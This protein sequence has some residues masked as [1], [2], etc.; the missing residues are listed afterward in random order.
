MKIYVASSWRNP[1]QPAVVERLRA[2]GH[3]VYDFRH[4]AEGDNGFHWSEIDEGWQQWT[5]ERYVAALEHPIAE[6]GF[7]KDKA[8]LDW[9][10]ACVLVLPC[11]RS[12]HLELGYAIGKGKRTAIVIAPVAGHS[13]RSDAPCSSCGDL[14]GCWVPANVMKVEP[15][16]M[17]KLADRICLS[18]DA[19][20][21][22][23]K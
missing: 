15:E 9:C 23:L 5:P 16:L 1:F 11:G 19:V 13:M 22:W 6:D 3:E 20:V 17:N 2:E 4:P 14:D 21:E 8:A 7:N 10:D 18:L 12:S